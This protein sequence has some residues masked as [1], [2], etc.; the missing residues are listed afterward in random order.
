MDRRTVIRL[1]GMGAITA[2]GT[3]FTTSV[4]A[5]TKMTLKASDVHPAGYPT[6]VAVESMGKKL[7]QATSGRLSVQMFA[8][9]Q[10]GGEK[11]A[12]EQA[13]IGAIQLARVSVGALGPVIEDL[14][15]FNLPFLFRNTAH[16]QKVI[17]G[18]IGQELLDKVT[19][20]PKAGLVGLCWM[21]AGARN[22]YDTKRPVKAIDDLKGLK[23]RVMGN[24]M[25]VEMMNALGGNGV[26]MGYDQVFSALQTGVVDGA[27]NNPPSF[28]FDNHYTV[29]KYYTLTEH[30]IVPEM[31][32][33]SRK[34]WDSLSKSDQDLVKQF[35]REAQAE[36]RVLWAK[37][38]KQA[39]EK[40]QASGIQVIEIAD[41]KPFQ[42]A[43]KP[44]WD[45]YGPR[46][47]EM[48]KR[49]QAVQ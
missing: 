33:F 26:A 24:P 7:E 42:D 43:V 48:I 30:L 20:N 46:F 29:A 1:G 12:I 40:A 13:Q 44:V 39:L 4:A 16:M 14:N 6:V 11:E 18:E 35:G 41:K 45:K 38:E 49:I 8:S 10:L 37:Y 5:Q 27:E 31:L 22:V 3:R 17:D 23:V 9:M 2:L 15:V 21:D 19:N 28:V 47:A 25:F 34:A 32:V 36:E